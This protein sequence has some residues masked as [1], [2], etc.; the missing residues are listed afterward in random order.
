M[1]KGI[2]RKLNLA[3]KRVRKYIRRN[4]DRSSYFAPG[5]AYEGYFGG[6]LKALTDVQLALEGAEPDSEFWK[7]G[8]LYW[9]VDDDN[10]N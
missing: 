3:I 5:L 10:K 7:A 9:E 1:A 6:Y 2:K 4:T 8:T